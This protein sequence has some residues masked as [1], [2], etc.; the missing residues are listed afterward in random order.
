MKRNRLAWPRK[1]ATRLALVAIAAGPGVLSGEAF[2]SGRHS[3]AVLDCMIIL[4]TPVS[5][6]VYSEPHAP[7]V[8][9]ETVLALPPDSPLVTIFPPPPPT[10]PPIHVSVPSLPP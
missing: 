6:P 3:T 7:I 1:Y 5:Y 4:I 10:L 8:A 9:P 2:A